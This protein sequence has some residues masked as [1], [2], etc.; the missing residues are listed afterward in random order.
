MLTSMNDLEETR[1]LLNRR[2]DEVV[3]ADPLAAL[4]VIGAV[5][6]DVAERRGAAVRVAVQRHSWSEIGSA[7]GV[8]K[9]AAHQK[10]AREWAETLKGELKAAHREA[11]TALRE[12][13]YGRAGAAEARRDAL[14]AELKG[15]NRRK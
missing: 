6:R 9:Q 8:S 3:A 5:Q 2:L 14:V 15:A 13:D 1:E 10:F 7:L 12:G 4:N 11:K